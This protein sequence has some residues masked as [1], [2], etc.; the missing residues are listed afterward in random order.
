MCSLFLCVCPYTCTCVLL[1]RSAC[2]LYCGPSPCLWSVPSWEISDKQALAFLLIQGQLSQAE[3]CGCHLHTAVFCVDFFRPRCNTSS[4][5]PALSAY[6]QLRIC[7][8]S[9]IAWVIGLYLAEREISRWSFKNINPES[10]VQ[11]CEDPLVVNLRCLKAVL[12]RQVTTVFW[13]T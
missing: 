7:H 4:Q 6:P 10:A 5:L 12:T 9:R 1:P 13:E 11:W 2:K 8:C 3:L